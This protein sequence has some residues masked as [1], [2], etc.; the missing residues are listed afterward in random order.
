MVNLT[1]LIIVMAIYFI[2]MIVISWMGKKHA[3]DLDSYL[4]AG[5]TAGVWLIIGSQAGSHIGNGVVVGGASEGA[6]VG[7]GGAMYGLA[8]A[9]SCI[10]VG[11]LLTKWVRRTGYRSMSEYFRDRYKSEVISLI[12]I[13]AETF[14]LV[15]VMG[16]QLMAG[17]AL[18]EALGLNGTVGVFAIAITVLIYAQISGLWGSYATSIVQTAIIVVAVVF[19]GVFLLNHGAI[20]TIASA[21]AAGTVPEKNLDFFS[22]YTFSAGLMMFLPPAISGFGEVANFQRINSGKDTKSVV[23]GQLLSALIVAFVALVPV[24]MGMYA[25]AAF[26]ATGNTAFFVVVSDILPPFWAAVVFTAVVAAIMSTIDSLY[27]VYAQMYLNDIY[28]ALI[29]PQANQEKLRK[30]TLPMNIIATAAGVIVAL[31]FSSIISLLS[32]AL[33]FVNAS[34][35]VPFLGAI[36]WKGANKHGAIAGAAIGFIFALLSFLNIYHLPYEGMTIFLPSLI[37]FLVVCLLTQNKDT[38]VTA[39]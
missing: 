31:S 11:T 15:G 32:N 10:V 1:L 30:W 8:C 5:K 36:L 38:S 4:D 14:V 23:I 39:A 16:S 12:F 35:L 19:C 24:F 13:L 3:T 27:M 17:K 18:F 2:A 34:C 28:T 6:A 20:E 29:N 25:N 26:G 7:I 37:V 22:A 33:T 21:V 9:F